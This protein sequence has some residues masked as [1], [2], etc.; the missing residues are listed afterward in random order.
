MSVVKKSVTAGRKS[1]KRWECYRDSEWIGDLVH[2]IT[3][4]EWEFQ[5]S[6]GDIVTGKS[7]VEVI[8]AAGLVTS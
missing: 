1:A 3:E 6:D 8:L 4:S 2:W 5:P 7:E